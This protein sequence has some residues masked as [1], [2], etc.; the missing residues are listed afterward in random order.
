[1]KGKLFLIGLL[2]LCVLVMGGFYFGELKNNQVNYRKSSFSVFTNNSREQLIP[3]KTYDFTPRRTSFRRSNSQSMGVKTNIS[4]ASRRERRGV[5]V[6][7][8]A[9]NQKGHS[10]VN[11]FRYS[12]N[13][14]SKRSQSIRGG[15]FVGGSNGGIIVA[16][17]SSRNVSSGGVGGAAFGGIMNRGGHKAFAPPTSRGGGGILIDPGAS[18]PG[19]TRGDDDILIDPGA[20]P[21]EETRIPVGDG[22]WI[23]LLLSIAYGVKI[24]IKNR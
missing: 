3:M 9:R 10:S 13:S 22:V 21:E 23:L 17:R 19:G 18:D 11:Y 6:R 1:M 5:A 14:K 15:G 20:D 8:H 4:S 12:R 16:G 24:G 2:T 7:S